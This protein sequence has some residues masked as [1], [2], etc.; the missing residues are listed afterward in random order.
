M[1]KFDNLHGFNVFVAIQLSKARA[2]IHIVAD[3]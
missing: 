2:Q 1:G 3:V